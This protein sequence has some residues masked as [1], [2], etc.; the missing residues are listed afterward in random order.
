[1]K[2]RENLIKF[3]LFHYQN[4]L[5]NL[6]QELLNFRFNHFTFV[7]QLEVFIKISKSQV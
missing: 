1:M 6:F 3:L 5:L 4:Y 7:F 2:I